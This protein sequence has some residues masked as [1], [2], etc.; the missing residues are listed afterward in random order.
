LADVFISY[1]REDRPTVERLA[2]ALQLLGFEVWW[3]L[4]LLTGENFRQVI[5]AVIDQC[6]VAVVVWS[7]SSAKSSFVLDEASYALRLGRLC[8]VRIDAVELPFG[9]GQT[10][11]EDLSDWSG[12]L[13]HPGFRGL[14][15][16]VEGRIGRKARLG[17]TVPV[18][19]RQ[20]AA[21][22]LEAF[23]AAQLA[24]TPGALRTFVANFS[25]GA[26]AP[27]VR[28]QIETIEREKPARS[29]TRA[30]AAAATEAREPASTA[31]RPKRRWGLRAA[32][33]VALAAAA[34]AGLLRYEQS[35]NA[36]R[37]AAED[38][39]R[40]AEQE[41]IAAQRRTSELETQAAVERAAR[42]RAE[43]RSETLQRKTEQERRALEQAG[44]GE[45][46][47]KRRDGAHSVDALHP[48]LR[49]VVVA[50]RRNALDAEGAALRARAAASLAE[51]AAARARAGRPGTISLTFDGGT[52]L[53]E[54]SGSTRNGHGV[55]AHGESSKFA[56]D[57]FAGQYKDDQRSGLGVYSFAD[58]AGNATKRLRREGEYAGN[59][60]NGLGILVFMSGERHAG[61]WS[62]GAAFGPG[63]RSFA[64]GRRYEGDYSTDQRNGLGVL[65]SAEG[66]VV[67]AGVWRDG[68]LAAALAP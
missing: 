67:S 28:D 8:P 51:A 23:K 60:P 24:A 56:G 2:G 20:A 4:E 46:E 30:A 35:Q 57:R 13:S 64:D 17:V 44:Q 27:F 42:E 63:V 7:E 47:R 15:A 32:V 1:K 61:L 31:E 40:R 25:G 41:R 58:N 39:R 14:V 21:A 18:A 36:A 11:A 45:A 22:E 29:R 48:S 16:A 66:K 59:L 3:D 9:F 50:A 55:T 65:W 38:A 34:T 53:G 37:E 12:E 43:Q 5:R 62:D 52:Y 26:L 33:A 6:R 19:Q 49:A 10:Q 68:K 54:G